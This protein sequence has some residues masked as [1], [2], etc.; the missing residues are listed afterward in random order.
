M[1]V[2]FLNISKFTSTFSVVC[3]GGGQ[4]IHKQN[5]PVTRQKENAGTPDLNKKKE[6]VENQGVSGQTNAID[7]TKKEEKKDENS[8]E[9]ILDSS[10]AHDPNSQSQSNSESK[11]NEKNGEVQKFE[12]PTDPEKKDGGKPEGGTTAPGSN[13][14]SQPHSGD[15]KDEN[16]NKAKSQTDTPMGGD[17]KPPT[18]DQKSQTT[19]T[20][21]TSSSPLQNSQPQL[22]TAT[23]LLPNPPEA[24]KRGLFFGIGFSVGIIVGVLSTV[25]YFVMKKDQNDKVTVENNYQ[26]KDGDQQSKDNDQE[27]STSD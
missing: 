3:A 24:S 7:E 22:N 6:D 1:I 21:E 18:E 16:E 9:K 12:T 11:E 5:D 20:A 4:D 13:P 8:L 14:P 2:N 27:K 10:N 17:Q 26:A 25:V 19:L 23:P 15:K